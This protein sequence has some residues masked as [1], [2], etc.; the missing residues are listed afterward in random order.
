VAD[1]VRGVRT[2]GRAM[3]T[4]EEI[5]KQLTAARDA[6]ETRLL[7]ALAR[8]DEATEEIQLLRKELDELPKLAVKRTRRAKAPRVT[9]DGLTKVLT[10]LGESLSDDSGDA[11][12]A[13]QEFEEP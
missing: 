13:E 4:R 9:V 6:V 5:E 8:R 3:T 7:D 10:A 12:A 2:E 11:R 1:L